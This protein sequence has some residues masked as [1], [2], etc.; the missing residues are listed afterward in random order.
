[1]SDEKDIARAAREYLAKIGKR[2]GEA[3]RGAKK[4]QSAAHYKRIQKLAAEARAKK[5]KAKEK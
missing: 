5:A 1:M 2:G 4:R 3:A